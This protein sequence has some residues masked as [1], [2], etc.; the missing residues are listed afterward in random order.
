MG[1]GNMGS[2]IITSARVYITTSKRYDCHNRFGIWVCLAAFKSKTDYLKYCRGLFPDEQEPLFIHLDW[3]DIPVHF[4][5]DKAI[6]A[7]VFRLIR[8][9]KEMEDIQQKG[10]AVWLSEHQQRIYNTRAT[11]IIRS[12]ELSYMGYFACKQ[13]F[14]EYYT[15]ETMGITKEGSPRFDFVSYTNQLFSEQFNIHKGFVFRKS[16]LQT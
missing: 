5:N 10:F 7:N 8:E 2:C 15:Q 6:S 13:Q 4:I 16:K 14:A 3:Q 11:D 1:G 12:F 9:V